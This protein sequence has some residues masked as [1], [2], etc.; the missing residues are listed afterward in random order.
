[1]LQA[2]IRLGLEANK[3]DTYG[4][5]PLHLAVWNMHTEV[6][7]LLLASQAMARWRPPWIRQKYIDALSSDGWSAL[8]LG[9]W[10]ND[11]S[12]VEILIQANANVSVRDSRRWTPIHWAAAN[13]GAGV[14][15]ALIKA[16]AS[17]STLAMSGT[18]AMHL[19]A[20][21]GHVKVIETLSS[22]SVS[23]LC[24]DSD[25]STPLHD[26]ADKGQV[27]AIFSLKWA[28]AAMSA[29]DRHEDRW[30][31]ILLQALKEFGITPLHRASRYGHREA[32]RALIA[33]GADINARDH[34]GR[35][36]LDWASA[37]DKDQVVV[38]LREVGAIV[39]VPK[40]SKASS[41]LK[42]ELVA[43]RSLY[44]SCERIFN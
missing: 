20:E 37:W 22:Y 6:V 24:C 36:P 27:G 42:P 30:D 5:T 4:W 19:A 28:G 25:G 39:T 35:T 7:T 41:S 1:M 29:N 18:V 32:V 8:H 13:N 33:I 40:E 12:L 34:E 17:H 38:L 2:Q 14:I 15:P 10:N 43:I 11:A 26:A 16:G 9:A 31:V 3:P 44:L 21:Y 23:P